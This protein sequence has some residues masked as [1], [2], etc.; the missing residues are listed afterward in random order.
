MFPFSTFK[1]TRSTYLH[2][3]CKSGTYSENPFIRQLLELGMTVCSWKEPRKLRFF[4]FSLNHLVLKQDKGLPFPHSLATEALVEGAGGSSDLASLADGCLWPKESRRPS[5]WP[6]GTASPLWCPGLGT[7]F[8]FCQWPSKEAD[9]APLPHHGHLV[10]G[11]YNL[12]IVQLWNFTG[13]WWAPVL[14]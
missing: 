4:P 2:I 10:S 3:S 5:C 12:Q 8:W 1:C 13:L 9:S 11:F 7:V 6:A 14:C